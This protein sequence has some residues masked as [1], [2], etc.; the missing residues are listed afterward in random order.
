MCD[1]GLIPIPDLLIWRNQCPLKLL[2]YASMKK[3]IIATDIPAHRFVFGEK[4]NSVFFIASG[5]SEEIAKAI[6]KI[7]DNFDNLTNSTMDLGN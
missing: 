6:S 4:S 3:V 2:E 1:V 7:Y 5:S